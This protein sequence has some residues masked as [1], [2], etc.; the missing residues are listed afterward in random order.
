MPKT[1]PE[2]VPPTAFI[3]YSW[4]DD[5][6]KQWV[7]DLAA[8]LRGDGVDVTLDQW[9]LQPGDR[10]PAFMETAIR[11]HDFV[12]IVCTPHYK[13]HSDARTGGVGYEGDIMTGELLGQ[14]NE[15]KFIPMLRRGEKTQALPSWLAGKYYIDLREGSDVERAYQDLLTTLLGTRVEPPLL[16]A[17]LADE[18]SRA[19][20][21]GSGPRRPAET[22]G[23]IRIL[24][25]I[26]DGVTE[27]R[28]DGTRGSG[29]YRVPLRLSRRPSP[30]WAQ[31]FEQ[32]WDHPPRFTTMHRPGIVSVQEDREI[33]DGTTIEEVERYHRDT[34]V[35]V[36][37][38]VNREIA[39][40]EEVQ[41]RSAEMER[42][43][44]EEHRRSVEDAAK[45]L[46]FD[47]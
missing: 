8:R 24:G 16:G 46:R 6:H 29:L 41:H 17:P 15:R 43:R 28:L 38:K 2:P 36:L 13:Q 27:P 45:R 37:E 25:V 44:R 9:Q 32:T 5:L 35:L 30:E 47:E 34:L 11:E 40:F 26:V 39:E 10:L 18:G 33:L 42:Q 23:P 3:S 31:L 14:G 19:R 21:V 20:R 22:E 7:R 4:D 1:Q 12:I